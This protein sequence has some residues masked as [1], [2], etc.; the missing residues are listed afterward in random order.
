MGGDQSKAEIEKSSGTGIEDAQHDSGP[1]VVNN[2]IWKYAK[3]LDLGHLGDQDEHSEPDWE[4]QKE[5][6]E[7]ELFDRERRIVEGATS[8]VYFRKGGD[9]SKYNQFV[10]NLVQK[11]I[12]KIKT[13]NNLK[14]RIPP[15]KVLDGEA[16]AALG[17]HGLCVIRYTSDDSVNRP[18][19]FYSRWFRSRLQAPPQLVS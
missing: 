18:L 7:L 5:Q 15:S 2:W 13:E 16:S 11:R 3:I 8:K 19:F 12:E 17:Q 14:D 1:D 6:A 9:E 4:K 10:E